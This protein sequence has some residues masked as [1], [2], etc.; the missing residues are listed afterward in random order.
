MTGGMPQGRAGAIRRA[1]A[2]VDDGSFEREL[3]R[4]VAIRTESQTLPA[5][6]PELER[7]IREEM[8]PSFSALGFTSRVFDNPVKGQGPI[9]LAERIED[10]R[11]PTV[12]GYGHGDVI[13]GQDKQWTK[14]NGPWAIARDGERLY[15]R[16]TADNKCQHTI[17]MAAMAAVM[18]ERGGKLGFNAKYIIETAEETGSQGLKACV[19]ANKDAFAAT[20][21]VASDGPRAVADRPTL[22]LGNRG[23]VTFDLVCRLREGAHHSGNWGGLL[24]DPAVILSHAIASFIGPR[25]GLRLRAWLPQPIQESVRAALSDV[26]IDGGPGAP[27]IDTWWGEPHLTGPEK[28]YAWNSFAVLAML[29]GNPDAPVNAIQ[30]EAR[31]RCQL[32]YVVGTKVEEVLPALRRHL[33]QNGYHHVTIEELPEVARFEATMTPPDSPWAAWAAKSMQATTGK[34]PAIIPSTGGGVPNDIFQLDLGL[35]TLWVPH[36]Y[37]GCSQHA[38]D[39]HVLMPV[40][41]SAM[42][43]MAGLY[44]DLGSGDVP[45]Q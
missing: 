45:K 43:V 35:P 18:A 10:P 38:P 7:Y 21:L 33:D 40:M 20:V 30:P 34:K 15:G 12:L 32:R 44:W 17:N 2:Y 6:L 11:L 5:S 26:V 39:E 24:A 4:R 29:A 19:T 27:E 14:G 41:R 25:G 13:R 42:A 22:V 37:A 16:G 28:V 1:E 23:A 3:G 36:S 31:A 9:L 8:V